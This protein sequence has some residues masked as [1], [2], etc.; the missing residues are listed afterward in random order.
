MTMHSL[1]YLHPRAF[2]YSKGN[3][4]LNYFTNTTKILIYCNLGEKQHASL[5]FPSRISIHIFV[6]GA[7]KDYKCL[8]YRCTQLVVRCMPFQTSSA[9]AVYFIPWFY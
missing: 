1:G 9:L 6:M 4:T 5:C 2:S 3:T 8:V 7:S